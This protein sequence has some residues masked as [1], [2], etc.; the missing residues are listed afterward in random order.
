[1]RSTGYRDETWWLNW[2]TILVSARSLA[3]LQDNYCANRD[4]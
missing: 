4:V 3:F 1:M 2:E